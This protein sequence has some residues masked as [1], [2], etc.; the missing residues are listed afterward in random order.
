MWTVKEM[1]TTER[2]QRRKSSLKTGRGDMWIGLLLTSGN[3]L[4]VLYFI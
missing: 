3:P 1:W 4:F 2:P